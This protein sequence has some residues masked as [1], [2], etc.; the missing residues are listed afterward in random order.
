[1]RSPGGVRRH[2][3]KATDAA[4]T[5]SSTSFEV[6]N[7]IAASN[8]PV[9]GLWMGSVSAVFTP[10]HS[11]PTQFI[12]VFLSIMAPPPRAPR[13]RRGSAPDMPRRFLRGNIFV[14]PESRDEMFPALR[15]E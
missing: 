1:M 15:D 2:V 13:F 5:A 3:R 6:D 4:S 7:G 8:S 9:A 11:P 14:S 12:N 10:R